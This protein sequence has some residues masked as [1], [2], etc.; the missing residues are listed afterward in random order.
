MRTNCIRKTMI[1][2]MLDL[3]NITQL[4]N[5]RPTILP[6]HRRGGEGR[7]EGAKVLLALAT[8]ALFAAGC[9]SEPH[10]EGP[11]VPTHEATEPVVLMDPGV[12]YSVTL[13][14]PPL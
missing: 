3:T 2:P 11:Y 8:A 6:L 12:H 10:D 13:G 14:G 9:A 4:F 7:G 5:A 1:R